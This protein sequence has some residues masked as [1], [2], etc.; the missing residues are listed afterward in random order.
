MSFPIISDS[1]IYSL[2]AKARTKFDRHL[3]A[4]DHSLRKLVGHARLY[5]ALDDRVRELRVMRLRKLSSPPQNRKSTSAASQKTES[6]VID[7]KDH[8]VSNDEET[9]SAWT[10]LNLDPK[11][12][13]VEDDQPLPSSDMDVDASVL[14]TGM[15]DSKENYNHGSPTIIGAPATLDGSESRGHSLA[16][17]KAIVHEIPVDDD[18]DSC[19]DSDSDSD[20]E[21]DPNF[22]T[23][24]ISSEQTKATPVSILRPSTPQRQVHW[25]NDMAHGLKWSDKPGDLKLDQDF[26]DLPAL[27]RSPAAQQQAVDDVPQTLSTT[28]LKTAP[29]SPQLCDQT[30][31]DL[32]STIYP[33]DELPEALRQILDASPSSEDPE[34]IKRNIIS[35][36]FFP[37]AFWNRRKPLVGNEVQS[38]GIEA[39]QPIHAGS[40]TMCVRGTNIVYD[41]Q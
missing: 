10:M 7:K 17:P 13:I 22:E 34:T 15:K 37:L 24:S 2:A 20:A 40:F 14:V 33:T 38:I 5:D 35:R 32:P 16:T 4:K 21:P 8:F 1:E 18:Y 41:H 39:Y 27:E 36:Y 12:A 25:N 9:G 31:N 11:C 3:D 29:L 28:E 30:F 6:S 19:S 26:E 23:P